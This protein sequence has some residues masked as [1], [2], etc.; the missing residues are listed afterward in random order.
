VSET[1]EFRGLW[2]LPNNETEQLAGTLTIVDGTVSLEVIG[3]FGHRLLSKT[4]DHATYSLDLAEHSRIV[5]M[6][7]DGKAITL[8]GHQAAPYTATFPGIA[9]ATYQRDIALV[10]KR[11]ADGEDIAFDEIAIRAS[12][13]NDWTRVSGFRSSIGLE[14]NKEKD[15]LAL[16]NIEV[17]FE[18]PD[19]IDIALAGGERARISFNATAR[20]IARQ[21]TQVA[22]QQDATFHFRFATRAGVQ[23][24]L[25]RVSQLRN[26]LSLAVGRPVAI[27]AVT[28]YQDRPDGKTD[29]PLPIEI[30]WELPTNPDPPIDQRQPEEMLFTLAEATPDLST[31]LKAWLSKQ[32]QMAPVFDL[33]FGVRHHASLPLE[34]RF[35][36]YAQAIETYDY[37]RRRAPGSETLAQRISAVLAECRTSSKRIVGSAPDD[38]ETFIDAFKLAR[39]YYTHYN[40]RLES[41][42]ARGAA[43]YLLFVQLQAL[44]EMS[45]LRELGFGCR[46]I[47]AVLERTGRYAQITRFKSV[48]A[49]G[50]S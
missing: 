20:G 5:G 43:L 17:R 23:E 24:V 15:S 38:E 48:V 42:V 33:F 32:A 46:A 1:R 13:L 44:I 26:F 2:W 36:T 40:P 21:T 3:D 28:G 31:V 12:D 41:R 25:T 11:F 47:D 35:L 8:E 16:L 19:D 7:T 9:T 4:K 39:N 27:L 29:H 30:V 22:L 18:A 34:V 45:L 50:D 37:R 49:D 10:G 6:S 14:K